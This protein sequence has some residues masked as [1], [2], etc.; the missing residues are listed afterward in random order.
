[1]HASTEEQAKMIPV[2]H[3]NAV[4]FKL[5]VHKDSSADSSRDIVPDWNCPNTG[6]RTLC[7]VHTVLCPVVSLSLSHPCCLSVLFVLSLVVTDAITSL[8]DLPKEKKIVSG[9]T[10][11][12]F[13]FS[14]ILA[15]KK[16]RWNTESRIYWLQRGCC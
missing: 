14:L 7:P 4:R 5:T 13:I 11:G 9:K 16:N 10:G 6:E 15:K 1:M 2:P 8:L 12:C 3:P